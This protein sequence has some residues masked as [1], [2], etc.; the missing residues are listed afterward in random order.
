M[1]R[2]RHDHTIDDKGR[3]SIPRVFRDE[4]MAEEDRPPMLVNQ[5]DF[6]ALYPAEIWAAEEQKLIEKSSLDPAAQNLR[7][8]YA[9]GSVECPVDSQGRILVPGFLREHAKL[10]T[11]VVVAGLF[12]YIEIWN[13]SRFTENQSSTLHEFDDIQRAVDQSSRS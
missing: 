8:F 12:E 5:K 10:D 6:L 13:P 7:R 3:L 2:G 1:F 9:A 4:L 11:K